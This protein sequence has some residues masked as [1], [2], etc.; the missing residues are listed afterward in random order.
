M[1]LGGL[2]QQ[3]S[4]HQL[5]SEISEFKNKSNYK[6]IQNPDS[7]SSVIKTPFIQSLHKDLC[8]IEEMTNFINE[9]DVS[10]FNEIINNCEGNVLISGIGKCD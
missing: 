7:S 9:N 8:A 1:V 4:K 10:R 6:S 2:P 3:E 5:A